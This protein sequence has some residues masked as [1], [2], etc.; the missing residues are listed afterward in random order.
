MIAIAG[1]EHDRAGAVAEEREALLVAGIDDP[2]VA[3]SAD[4]QRAVAVAGRHELRRDDQGEDEA[5][6]GRLDVKG[7][8]GQLEPVLNQVGRG[9]KRHVGR[10]G[11]HHQKVDV[12]RL[13]PA[14]FRQ[15]MAACVQRSLV[16]WCGSANRRSWIPVRLTIHSGSKPW[17]LLQ[18]LIGHDQLGDIAPRTQNPHAQQRA[19]RRRKMDLAVAHERYATDFI[20]DV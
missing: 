11:R 8:T 17:R 2:A 14:A 12:G 7:G 19:R 15:R 4:H 13:A 9:G 1:R 20:R 3:V 6:A 10:E 5:R 16:A 18:V